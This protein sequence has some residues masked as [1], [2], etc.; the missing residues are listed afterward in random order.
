MLHCEVLALG[1]TMHGLTSLHPWLEKIETPQ[2][3]VSSLLLQN[4]SLG[5]LLYCGSKY[6]IVSL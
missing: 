6:G 3:E 5:S 2:N 1:N 4:C